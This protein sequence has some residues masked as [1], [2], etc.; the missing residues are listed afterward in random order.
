MTEPAATIDSMHR[1]R[2]P[3]VVGLVLVGLGLIVALYPFVSIWRAGD[4]A[5]AQLPEITDR[6]YS[7]Q[8]HRLGALSDIEMVLVR[9]TYA[10]TTVDQAVT[11]LQEAGYGSNRSSFRQWYS[12]ECCG[13]WDAVVVRP[14]QKGQD[15]E[16]AITMFDQGIQSSWPLTVPVGLG[17]VGLGVVLTVGSFRRTRSGPT[18][19]PPAGQATT[20]A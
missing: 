13:A 1:R 12:K 18:P 17:L 16:L 11:W 6:E 3:Q 19:D 5:L 8:H 10:D 14:V 9:R 4:Q 15:V 7:D 2:L 20:T